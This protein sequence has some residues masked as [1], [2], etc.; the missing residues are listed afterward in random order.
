M[1]SLRSEDVHRERRRRA[2]HTNIAT[3]S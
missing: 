1:H 2:A 3:A